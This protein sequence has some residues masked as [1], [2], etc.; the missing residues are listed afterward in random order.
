MMVIVIVV[1][2][3]VV[4]GVVVMIAMVWHPSDF[5]KK[6]VAFESFRHKNMWHLSHFGIKV[7]HVRHLLNIIF[8]AHLI[9]SLC[10]WGHHLLYTHKAGP[11]ADS[12][13]RPNVYNSAANKSSV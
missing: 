1:V 9:G 2:I 5:V 12:F 4:M 8:L 11:A 6:Y 7:W 3:V 13:S 10:R